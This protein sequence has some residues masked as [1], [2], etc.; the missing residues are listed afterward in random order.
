MQLFSLI[1]ILPR[2]YY[3]QQA[4][5]S[6]T[7]LKIESNFTCLEGNFFSLA[8][9]ILQRSAWWLKSDEDDAK[10]HTKHLELASAHCQTA[11]HLSN[12]LMIAYSARWRQI[13]QLLITSSSW[14]K[15]I[16]YLKH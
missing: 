13:Y 16:Y 1:K 3:R 2:I 7:Q 5:S 15:K 11:N 10:L 4:K 9:L 12:Q 8:G 6:K 14:W